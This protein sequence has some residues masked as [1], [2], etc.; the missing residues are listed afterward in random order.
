VLLEV[1]TDRVGIV[2][3]AGRVRLVLLVVEMVLLVV[4]RVHLGILEVEVRTG[5]VVEVA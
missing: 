1:G 2:L 3:V 4:G 5:L